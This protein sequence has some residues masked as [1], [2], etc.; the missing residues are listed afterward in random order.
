LLEHYGGKI[1]TKTHQPPLLTSISVRSY[2]DGNHDFVEVSQSKLTPY[3]INSIERMN[4]LNLK[5]NL[6]AVKRTA[7]VKIIFNLIEP[8]PVWGMSRFWNQ[9]VATGVWNGQ[10]HKGAEDIS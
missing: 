10:K 2:H 3:I 7:V 1:A 4:L 5:K 6:G 8:I 9:S